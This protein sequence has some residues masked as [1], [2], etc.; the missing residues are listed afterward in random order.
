M[1]D[2]T[3]VALVVAAVAFVALRQEVLFRRLS[4]SFRLSERLRD[5]QCARR[6]ACDEG[7]G[8]ST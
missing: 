4:G 6:H 2:L 1:G 5:Q 7:E 3:V 8:K